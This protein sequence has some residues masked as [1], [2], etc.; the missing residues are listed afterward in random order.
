MEK[1]AAILY[2][3]R[4]HW[5]SLIIAI[6]IVFGSLIKVEMDNS[7]KAW[8]S[9][10]DQDYIGYEEYRTT[11][12]GGRFLIV[13]LRSKKI[14]SLDVLRYIKKKTEEFEDLPKVKR[15]HSLANAN[16]VIGTSE[17][18]EINPLLSELKDNNLKKIKEYATEDELFREYLVSRDGTFTAIVLTFEDMPSEAT[19]KAVHQVKEIAYQEKPKNVELFLSGDMRVYTEFNRF[20]KQNQKI[21]PLLVIP[22]ISLFIFILFQS[23]SKVFII[24]SVVGMS[25]CWA[26]GFYSV[27]G[28]EFNVV[29]GMLIPLVVILSIATSI[30][31]M[32]YF[33]EARETRNKEEA[34]KNTIAYITIPCFI[35]SIT[36]AFGLL[37]LSI[38][39]IDA[40]KH[41]G[42]GSAAGVM[43]AFVISIIIVPVFITL[44]PLDQ[45]IRKD[46]LLKKCLQGIARFNQRRF[47]YILVVAFFGFIFF[48]WGITKIKIETNQIEWFPKKEDCYISTM[49][50][51]RNLSGVGDVEIVIKGKK[52]AL[53]DP[54]VLKRI[55]TLS[56]EIRK[57]PRIKKVI[58]LADY[59]KNINKALKEDNPEQYTIPDSQSLIAQE[60]FLFSL[61][62]DG[63]KELDNI[64]TSDYSQ[65][66][67]SVKT[68]SMP[69]QESVI[70]GN[71]LEDMAKE[72]FLGTGIHVSLTG[73]TFLYNLMNRY[74]MESQIK[75]FSLAF[76]LVIGVLFIAFWSAKYGGL[77]IIANL[78][79]IIFIIGIMGWSGI[80]LNTGT[81]MVASVALG[82]AADD[83]IH[84]I[85][86][87]RKE[88]H[89]KQF[90]P[91]DALSET[92]VSV[93]RAILFTSAINIAGFL[94]LLISGFQPTREFGMLIAMTLFFA[95][96]GDIVVL[97]SVIIATSKFA[98]NKD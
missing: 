1:F 63:R 27:L 95:L 31:I 3:F 92:I 61:S 38:S 39:H 25:L 88:L 87:F 9:S 11:F 58:S 54:D 77:S 65:G 53:K 17:G 8:F 90:P 5:L 73:T 45:K 79:P 89:S 83:T 34:F 78:L 75:G 59:V 48:G 2:R 10:T 23:F 84:F 55:D 51:D 68:E 96:M 33:I 12:E 14:F 86:R 35:T 64:V 93:G 69:S 16:K 30:H 81:V 19:D 72:T 60:L 18:I 24:L 4:F 57:I 7:L 43:F 41:F 76:L 71:L 66:R 32:E 20:T 36:T 44:L 80:T 98:K 50:V 46:V 94:I 91:H 42:I 85:S 28:Y 22:I 62:D 56:L 74:L 37:S 40:V 67:V 47:K 21:L 97:P 52:D 26:L 49:L 82:I 6:T 29:T 15:V 70:L 13:A